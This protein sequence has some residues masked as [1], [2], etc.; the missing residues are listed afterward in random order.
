VTDD[1]ITFTM[2]MWP[3]EIRTLRRLEVTD[4]ELSKLETIA[5][6]ATPGEWRW[7][8]D[9]GSLGSLQ[10][11]RSHYVTVAYA[12]DSG[13]PIIGSVIDIGKND[14][15]HIAA[16]SPDVVLRL[17]AEL[18]ERREREEDAMLDRKFDER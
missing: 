9:D 13:G 8:P 12:R 3:D 10:D 15:E 17:I 1:G 7:D 6:A 5:K 16:F 4:D 18:R 2:R 11:E 14:A